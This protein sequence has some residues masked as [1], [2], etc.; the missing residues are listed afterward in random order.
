MKKRI[1]KVIIFTLLLL[2]AIIFSSFNPSCAKYFKEEEN[3][4]YNLTIKQLYRE[5]NNNEYSVSI[6][7]SSTVNSMV[8]NFKFIK[9]GYN[10]NSYDIN[11]T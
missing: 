7:S 6:N 5:L 4:K 3:L 11:I 8:L 10:I 9:T 2:S 1:N